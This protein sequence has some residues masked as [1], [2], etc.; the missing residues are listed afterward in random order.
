MV[1]TQVKNGFSSGSSN[2]VLDNGSFIKIRLD[3]LLALSVYSEKWF[4]VK[5]FLEV[6]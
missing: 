6:I 4:F 3:Y 1:L 2:F 5:D